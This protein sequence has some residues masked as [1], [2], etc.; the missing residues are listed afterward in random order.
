MRRYFAQLCVCLLLGPSLCSDADSAIPHL[1]KQGSATQLFVHGRPF[2]MLGGELGN[3]SASDLKYL[4]PIWPKLQAMRLNTILAPVYWELVEPQEGKFDFM[5]VD[6][7]IHAA[8]RSDLKVVLLWFG[9]WKN[10]MSCYAPYWV[11]TNQQRFPRA[12]TR[13]GQAL[14][15]LTPFSEENRN[16]D[17]RAFAS[18]MKHLRAVDGS[19]STVVMVQVENEIGMIPEAR[20]Y[21]AAAEAAFQRKVPAELMTFLQQHKDSLAA[22]VRQAWNTSGMTT[23]GTWE[24][25]FGRSLQ[26][27]EIFMAWHFARYTDHVAQAGKRE[28]PLPL[29]VNAALI[30][31]NHQPGQYPS[32]GPLPHL[33]EVWRAAA[34]HLDFF[35]PDIYFKNFA[36]WL[37]KY[38]RA[39]NAVFIP[40]VDHRQSVTNAFFAFARH[41]AMGYSPF[42]L[43][44]AADPER[45]QF[46]QGYEILHQLAPLIL[47]H[48]GRGTMTGFL[49]DSTSQSAQIELG[50]YAFTV[51][52][53]YTW[54]YA[55]RRTGET[56][57]A[58]GLIIM[59]AADEF[60]VAGSGVVVTFQTSITDGRIAGIASMEEGRF[61]HGEWLAGRRLNGD[62]THQGRHMHLPGGEYGMQKVKLYTYK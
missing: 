19:H 25:V 39:G 3:S 30:R 48:Q 41:D 13:Q 56:P 32:A 53:G 31:P 38:D 11:K 34:P 1:R 21:C 46:S 37:G 22:E 33:M 28:Y 49:L 10:S 5:L 20:D 9:S 50:A 62:Q 52:H 14:E 18:L 29:F 51:K 45:N 55:V 2:L 27:D 15:I 4:A 58:G 6:S 24:E 44:S 61:V 36:E 8:R 43:E 59:L 7:L 16:A 12:R 42:A 47:A 23:S 26:T 54:P 40:E 35:A 60:L 57:R 17:A